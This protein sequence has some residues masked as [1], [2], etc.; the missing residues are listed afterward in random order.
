MN[1]GILKSFVHCEGKEGSKRK[2]VEDTLRGTCLV[3]GG[4]L[5][6]PFRDF[7]RVH[8]LS[9]RVGVN[10]HPL[11]KCKHLGPFGGLLVIYRFIWRGSVWRVGVGRECWQTVS[12]NPGRGLAW[13]GLRHW[14]TPRRTPGVRKPVGVVVVGGR[15]MRE[16]TFYAQNIMVGEGWIRRAQKN[17]K[18]V[19][20]FCMMLWR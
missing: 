19:E 7:L 10:Q 18:A 13:V 16:A 14:D 20:L 5:H 12:G 4:P 15:R 3:G 8:V 17:L 2:K 11:S 9:T 1:L 6:I